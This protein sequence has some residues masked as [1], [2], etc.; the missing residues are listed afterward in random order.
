[1]PTTVSFLF[2]NIRRAQGTR[3]YES[4]RRLTRRGVDVFLFAEPPE[5]RDALLATLNREFGGVYYPVP[6]RSRRLL[7]LSRLPNTKWDD[8]FA[9]NVS[10]R[11]TAHEL[12]IA[13]Q[14]SLLLIAA[15]LHAPNNLDELD[16]A[17]WVR[18]L[19]PDIRQLEADV[20]HTR[21]ILVGD[22]NMN[23]FDP[24]LVGTTGLHAVI[25]RQLAD[26]VQRMK[27][28]RGH[29]PFYN[30]MWSLLG[31]RT[32]NEAGGTKVAGTF[33]HENSQA[34]GSSFWRM[35][36]QVLLRPD[37]MRSLSR[38]EILESD[39]Q[40]WLVSRSGRPCRVA[41]SDHLPLFFELSLPGQ[42]MI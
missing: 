23:P 38:L 19:V 30:P 33:F 10:D 1:M 3:F 32:G 37:L 25:S 2:W 22:L 20:A 8:R 9:D 11:I 26:S 34:L 28:R 13:G 29:L 17:E 31:D 35:Y 27:S 42:E 24:G 15:H 36:D 21:T 16:R 12:T 40:D 14:S 7:L 41:V 6:S 39:G 18:K 5:D 4:F